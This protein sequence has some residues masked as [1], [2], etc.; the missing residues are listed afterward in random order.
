MTTKP[1]RKKRTSCSWGGRASRRRSE[2]KRT[3]TRTPRPRRRRAA[4]GTLSCL[5]LR[6][7]L[8]L[9]RPPGLRE[10]LLWGLPF[11]LSRE[12]ETHRGDDVCRLRKRRK[13]WSPHFNSACA[14]NSGLTEGCASQSKARSCT[15]QQGRELEKNGGSGQEEAA[16]PKIPF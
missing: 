9:L 10:R 1:A 5:C 6:K 3:P 8:F 11:L 14:L 7:H 2:S 13:C 16:A 4:R 15:W 12:G